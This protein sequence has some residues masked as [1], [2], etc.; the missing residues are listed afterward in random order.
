M[1]SVKCTIIS[2]GLKHIRSVFSPNSLGMIRFAMAWYTFSCLES[3]Y[4]MFSHHSFS[5]KWI[6]SFTE[7]QVK[8]KLWK[9]TCWKELEND[10][11]SLI[12]QQKQVSIVEYKFPHS[13]LLSFVD[14]FGLFVALWVIKDLICLKSGPE[15]DFSIKWQ[16]SESMS[17][18]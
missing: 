14:K 7:M 15:F 3:Y 5:V 4:L 10:T 16:L 18:I 17:S 13:L 11:M 1:V 6:K 9:R 2:K 12:Q 8:P